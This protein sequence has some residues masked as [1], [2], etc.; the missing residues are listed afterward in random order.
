MTERAGAVV[1]GAGVI[2]LA[3]ARALALRDIDTVILEAN[4]GIGMETSSRNSELIHAGIY[5]PA[6]TL[7]ARLCVEGRRRLYE[8]CASRGVEHRRCGKLIVATRAGREGALEK[9]RLR[10]AGNGVDDLR[11]LSAAELA[12]LEPGLRADAALHSP[13]TGIVD[14][15]GLMLA[16]LGEA[17]AHGATLALRSPLVRAEARGDGFLL[18]I[19]GAEPMRLRADRLVNAAGLHATRVAAA[20]DGLDASHIPVLHLAKGQY[21]AH[22]GR[23]P[24][25]RLVYPLDEPEQ[26]AVPCTFDLGGQA[27]FGPSVHPV[28]AIDYA[29]D[30]SQA[31]ALHDGAR[32]YW[33]ALP[34]GVL[35][36][37]H[38]GIWPRLS[39]PGERPADFV[40]QPPRVHAVPG[41]VNLFG[42]DSPGITAS[43]ALAELVAD[44]LAAP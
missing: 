12:A 30:E 27:R 7:K 2:G 1:V 44:E 28:E 5:H 24:F 22:P 10:A 23:A 40:V 21:Y 16:L 31:Q 35:K 34:D 39:R 14:T 3:C 41:L 19:G 43:L 20:I 11:L 8:F 26:F 4:P 25:A 33:P 36:P 32:Q 29:A 37:A 13:S 17:E 18:E 38:C 15:H 9:L 42:I 6:G